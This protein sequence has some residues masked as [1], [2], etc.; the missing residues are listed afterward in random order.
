MGQIIL[1]AKHGR[2][3]WQPGELIRQGIKILAAPA[4]APALV[5]VP[6]M[7]EAKAKPVKK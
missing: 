6:V 3:V 1:G 7:A 4:A 2:K 5:P